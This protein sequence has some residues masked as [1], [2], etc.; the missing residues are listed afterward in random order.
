[1]KTQ[2]VDSCNYF[3]HCCFFKCCVYRYPQGNFRDFILFDGHI[4]GTFYGKMGR[5][6]PQSAITACKK[7]PILLFNPHLGISNTKLT[8]QTNA[9]MVNSTYQLGHLINQLI[10]SKVFIQRYSKRFNLRFLFSR[11]EMSNLSLEICF[12]VLRFIAYVESNLFG[13]TSS[14]F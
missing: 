14:V 3:E 4:D 6:F 11:S 7:I 10:F 13:N 8:S 2:L 12:W 9:I 1:M 5:F